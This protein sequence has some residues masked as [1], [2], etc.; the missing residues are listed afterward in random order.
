MALRDSY[1]ADKKYSAFQRF[2]VFWSAMYLGSS[3]PHTYVDIYYFKQLSTY[4][5]YRACQY[6][7]ST[8]LDFSFVW[9]YFS[10]QKLNEAALTLKRISTGMT[11]LIL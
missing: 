8:Y 11:I 4:Q 2:S 9:K 3:F 1:I 5:E 6:C 7:L 10:K